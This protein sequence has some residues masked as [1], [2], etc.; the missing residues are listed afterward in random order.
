[1]KIPTVFYYKLVNKS[2]YEESYKEAL[3]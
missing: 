2:D 3:K 1:L